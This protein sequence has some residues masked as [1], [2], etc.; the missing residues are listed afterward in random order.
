MINDMMLATF[1]N[2]A[3]TPDW[4]LSAAGSFAAHLDAELSGVLTTIVVPDRSNALSRRLVGA[5][6]AIAAE[7]ARSEAEANVLAARFRKVIGS[8]D[9]HRLVRLNSFNI[10]D[11]EPVARHARLFDGALLPI[12]GHPDEKWMV[13]ALIFDTGRP[14]LLMPRRQANRWDNVLIAWD[15]S[16]AA[17]RAL[18]DAIPLCRR[19]RSV[20]VVTIT[21]EKPLPEDL[22][23]REVLRHLRRHGIEASKILAPLQGD[24]VGADLLAHADK[25]AA[26][27]LVM[28]G[29][30]HSRMREFVLGGATRSVIAAPPLPVLL[31]H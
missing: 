26:D 28:G 24:D 3:P 15:G 22:A 21:G 25:R 4:A 8:D 19:A 29:F 30:G 14:V 2:P 10:A 17:A 31:S 1:S 23:L 18:A 20:E 11:P 12:Y 5:D 16:R 6:A 27:I 7:N 13:Q 9:P